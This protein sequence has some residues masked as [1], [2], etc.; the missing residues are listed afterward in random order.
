MVGLS[1]LVAL[2]ALVSCGLAADFR[3]PIH[4]HHRRG[5]RNFATK[6]SLEVGHRVRHHNRRVNKTF[7]FEQGIGYYYQYDIMLKPDVE[8]NAVPLGSSQTIR[9]PN[10]VVPYQIIG[11]FTA[12]EL[13]NIQYTVQHY[14]ALTCVRFVP[15][16]TEE[17]YIRINNSDTGCWS[18]VGRSMSNDYNL[19]NLQNPGCMSTGTVAHEFM[20]ALGFYH[21]FTRPDR[22][23]YISVDTTALL[24]QY[25]TTSFYNANFA[26]LSYAQAELYGI[27]YYYGSVM[28][29][30]KWG[31]AASYSKPVMNNKTYW[32]GDFG[33]N[34]GLSASDVLAINYMYCNSSTVTTTTLAPTTT[35]AA[36]TT[37]TT[38]KLPTTTTTVATTTT[39][40]TKS[41]TTTTKAPTT[42]TTT[43][44]AT[45]TTTTTKI[46]TT[47]TTTAPTTTT[48]TAAPSTKKTAICVVYL[49]RI[50]FFYY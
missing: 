17:Q 50:C 31:G 43:T 48:T 21:E 42:T 27:P 34:T 35:T 11:S 25:Q 44:A 26:K 4:R 46:P 41:P 23:E 47:T 3:V 45:T 40:T 29:Y 5:E 13:A 16:T 24:P 1:L 30:S 32:P 18:Y 10:A 6:P 28:H 7:A 15:R 36:T 19:V 37:T 20:H 38:A 33:N 9:W 49:F 12:S 14:A 22:D 8:Q 2:A 39:T